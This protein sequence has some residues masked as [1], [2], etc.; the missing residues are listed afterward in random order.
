MGLKASIRTALGA[1]GWGGE[2][3]PGFHS[4]VPVPSC[5]TGKGGLGPPTP[6]WADPQLLTSACTY[7]AAPDSRF[8]AFPVL[9]APSGNQI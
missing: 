2:S 8:S 9:L 5:A 3:G 1:S 4:I 7:P 6:G